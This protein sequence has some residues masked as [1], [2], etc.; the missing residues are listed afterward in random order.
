MK[1]SLRKA[2]ALQ[3]AITEAINDINHREFDTLIDVLDEEYPEVALDTEQEKFLKSVEQTMLLMNAKA[4]IRK[5]VGEANHT[6]GINTLFANMKLIENKMELFYGL[7]G[8]TPRVKPSAYQKKI[9]RINN[10]SDSILGNKSVPVSVITENTI[11]TFSRK[12][13]E[14]SKEKRELSEKLLEL[15]VGTQIQLPDEVHKVLQK[16]NIVS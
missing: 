6:C 4:E 15:N 3:E 9:T 1:V 10:N 5:L 16:H 7:K 14:V 11:D 13:K 12:Y 2:A 8:Y